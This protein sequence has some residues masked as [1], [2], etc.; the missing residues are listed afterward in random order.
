MAPAE[1]NG[2]AHTNGLAAGD[3]VVL[4]LEEG[5]HHKKQLPDVAPA[6]QNGFAHTNGAANGLPN[7]A[8]TGA[9]NRVVGEPHVINITEAH[10]RAYPEHNTMWGTHHFGERTHAGVQQRHYKAVKWVGEREHTGGCDD[11]VCG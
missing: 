11:D 3:A 4:A 5:Q 7:G 6:Q 8:T 2:T 1:Q 10:A 9:A